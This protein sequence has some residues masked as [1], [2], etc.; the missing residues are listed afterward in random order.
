MELLNFLACWTPV[1]LLTILAVGFRKP[2][3]DLSLYGTLFT[4]LLVVGYFHTPVTVALRAGL[5]G[6]VTSVPL[7]LVIFAGILLS[8]L[9]MAA[10]AL[11]RIVDWFMSGVRDGYH[12]SLLIALGV[13][14]FAEGAGV[15][16]EPVVAPMLTA[17]GVEPRGAA[18]LSIIGYA[19]LM[20]LE[21]AGIIITVLS[22]VTGISIEE[23]GLASA[24]LSIPA[25]LAMTLCVPLF[26]PRPLPGLR[27]WLFTMVCGVILGFAALACVAWLA[28]SISGMIAGLV[29]ILT[30]VMIGRRKMSLK[31]GI[32]R[33]LAPF[34]L[35]LGV[36]LALNSVP[37]LKQLTFHQLSVQVRLIPV[38]THHLPSFI[39]RLSLPFSGFCP[40][41]QAFRC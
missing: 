39:F 26:L 3:I 18:A 19:G 15:I 2:A 1:L 38:H 11:T 22:L 23:L 36:L 25:T 34:L 30:L 28:V 7:I 32:L 27:R 4:L 24:W 31:G 10:G 29:L 40:V 16:A 9:L 37:Y 35:I 5:D 20:T 17:A 8:S 33:D 21:M 6:I 13:G 14:N 12:R 41:R